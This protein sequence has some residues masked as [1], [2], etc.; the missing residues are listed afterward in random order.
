VPP[1]T[2]LGPR[3]EPPPACAIHTQGCSQPKP[4]SRVTRDCFF[5]FKSK[6]YNAVLERSPQED[7]QTMR[8]LR[9]R[10]AVS[11]YVLPKA[12]APSLA[13]KRGQAHEFP[14]MMSP[15]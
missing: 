10:Y 11:V 7:I 5:F 13:G 12:P 15:F 6:I 1:Q 3:R 8:K 9:L 14:W 2:S 4:D